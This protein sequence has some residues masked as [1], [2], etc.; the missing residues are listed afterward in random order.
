M[1]LKLFIPALVVALL[2]AGCGSQKAETA[3]SGEAATTAPAMAAPEGFPDF[4]VYNSNS[5]PVKLS[6]YLGKPIVLNFWAS[7]CGPCKA[8]MPAF[9]KAY[10]ELG[11]QV[12]FLMVNVGEHMDE[13]SAFIASSG[14]S[15]PVLYDVN[16]IASY[17]YQISS[18]PATFFFDADGQI[19]D[20]HV[21]TMQESDLLAA[22]EKIK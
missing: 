19:V 9:Q 7:W 1:K 3:G 10:E 12:Q 4:T 22:I 20:A 11:D 13:G 14:Y 5:D 21:G 18:I 16:S 15:F 6:D 8:E 17:T 2:L